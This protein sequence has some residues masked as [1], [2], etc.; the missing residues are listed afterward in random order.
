MTSTATHCGLL[1]ISGWFALFGQATQPAFVDGLNVDTITKVLFAVA[2]VLTGLRLLLIEWRKGGTQGPPSVVK[3]LILLMLPV[4]VAFASTGC[5][6]TLGR[7]LYTA[8]ARYVQAL[9]VA[10]A[11][12]PAT[13]SDYNRVDNARL[14]AAHAIDVAKAK[15]TEAN[16]GEAET[17]VE[18]FED[19]VQK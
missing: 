8:E 7:R 18:A 1:G 19:E 12:P 3:A 5:N 4:A 14:Q 13:L 6:P 9:K 2:A 17:R 15:T 11:T 16:V 10:N